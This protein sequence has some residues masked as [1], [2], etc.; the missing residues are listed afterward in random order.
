MA[1]EVCRMEQVILFP[2]AEPMCGDVVT[3]P[4]A[5]LSRDIEKD[6]EKYTEKRGNICEKEK[7]SVLWRF[8]YVWVPSDGQPPV[9]LGRPMNQPVGGAS[10]RGVSGD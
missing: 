4:Q 5:E 6:T 3:V 8:Q 9:S 2:Q 1:S 7:Y 10:G